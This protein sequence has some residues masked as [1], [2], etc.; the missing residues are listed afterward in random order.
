MTTKSVTTSVHPPTYYRDTME[1]S[2]NVK[3]YLHPFPPGRRSF[4][5]CPRRQSVFATISSAEAVYTIRN[6]GHCNTLT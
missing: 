2:L 4:A 6:V 5:I 1:Q 3:V